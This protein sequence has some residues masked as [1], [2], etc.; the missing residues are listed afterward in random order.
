[1]L[2]SYISPAKAAAPFPLESLNIGT[3]DVAFSWR[4]TLGE[5]DQV[6][7]RWVPGGHFLTWSQGQRM[8]CKLATLNAAVPGNRKSG[9]RCCFLDSFWKC[10]DVCVALV[11]CERKKLDPVAFH[12]W[13]Q[14]CT[15]F[16]SILPRP[17]CWSSAPTRLGT[18]RREAAAAPRA[19]V[20][21]TS[22]QGCFGLFGAHSF[23]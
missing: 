14:A 18:I 13:Q 8:W 1:M 23:L 16:P 19:V 22:L 5:A 3:W 10:S 9:F 11:S 7:L 4:H 20:V 17:S 2:P 12:S 15:H 6:Q 21:M